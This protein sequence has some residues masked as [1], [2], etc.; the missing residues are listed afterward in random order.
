M[1]EHYSGTTPEYKQKH[2]DIMYNLKDEENVELNQRLAAAELHPKEL[3]L[4]S[5]KVKAS[6]SAILI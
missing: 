4:M 3:A 2:R 1:F 6:L 5:P